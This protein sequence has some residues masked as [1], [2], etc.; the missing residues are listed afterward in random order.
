MK[1]S[2]E[3]VFEDGRFRPV[4][5][6]ALQFCEGQ[7]VRLVVDDQ[8]PVEGDLIQLAARVYEGLDDKEISAIEEIASDRGDFFSGGAGQ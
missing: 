8:Y 7:H 5:N 3:A 1:Q 2:I 4:G 6:H